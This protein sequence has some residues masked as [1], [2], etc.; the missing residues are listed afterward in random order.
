MFSFDAT[1]VRVPT[2]RP[3]VRSG[4]V[5]HPIA[6]RVRRIR[7]VT[8]ARHDAYVRRQIAEHHE[9]QAQRYEVGGD[10]SVLP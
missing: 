8:A 4:A 9:R 2:A 1:S 6:H 10:F 7:A 3:V 5:R